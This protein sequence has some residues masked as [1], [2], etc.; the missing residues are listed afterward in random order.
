VP[1]SLV[2]DP[3]GP[4]TSEFRSISLT[5]FPGRELVRVYIPVDGSGNGQICEFQNARELNLS[6]KEAKNRRNPAVD[7]VIQGTM[8][9]IIYTIF[10]GIFLVYC[11]RITKDNEEKHDKLIKEIDK[12]KLLLK[13]SMESSAR[14][15]LLLMSRLSDYAK[16]LSFWRDT[17]RGVIYTHSRNKEAANSILEQVSISL[18][19][20]KTDLKDI[21]DFETIQTLALL[22]QDKKTDSSP[23]ES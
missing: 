11:Y 1:L 2:T 21:K 8:T 7:I 4:G 15:R 9:A 20:Y 22:T 23:Q 19:T 10:F 5:G 14:L 3:N 6:Y 13:E 18:K 12:A 16:E 17:I